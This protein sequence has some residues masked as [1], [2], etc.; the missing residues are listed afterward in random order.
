MTPVSDP[1]MA[2]PPRLAVFAPSP[3]VTVTV[4]EV[5]SGAPEIHFHAGGQGFWVARMAAHLGARVVLCAPVGGESGQVLRVLLERHGIELRSVRC[6]AP[7]GAYVHDRRSGERVE[8][9]AVPSPALSRHEQDE[10]F[11]V[12]VTAGLECGVMLLTGSDPADVLPPDLYERLAGDLRRNGCRVLADLCGQ[13]LEG[14]LA[15]GLDVVKLSDEELAEQGLNGAGELDGLRPAAEELQKAGAD[16]VLIT[17]AVKGALVLTGEELLELQGPRFTALDPKGTGDSMFAG[18][19]V[20]LA[21]GMSLK[22]ALR[23]AGAAGALNATRHGLGS[24]HRDEVERLADAV[25]VTVPRAQ[26]P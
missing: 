2:E 26:H 14:A 5:A 11:G 23:E 3:I 9:A 4:E 24:G 18:L 6:Q 17:R 19:G 21:S 1:E 12:A 7:N 10:L 8:V 16:T 13:A 20:G 15:G 22:D 25:T